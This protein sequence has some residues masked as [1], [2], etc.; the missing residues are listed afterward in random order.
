[1]AISTTPEQSNDRLLYVSASAPADPTLPSS[2]T[3]VG[4]QLGSPISSA[5]PEVETRWKTGVVTSFGA[6]KVT[7]TV[8]VFAPETDD[9][10]QAIL[11]AAQKASPKTVV[12]VLL[13][14]GVSG[15]VGEYGQAY[16]GSRDEGDA[17][18]QG[19]TRSYTLGFIN[20]TTDFT[21]A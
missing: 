10:G 16:V 19:L 21:V 14:T 12:H 6:N 4:L 5:A 17:T 18:D 3:V 2:Y 8:E 13:T 11:R 20:E 1:M 9:D 7:S 15:S